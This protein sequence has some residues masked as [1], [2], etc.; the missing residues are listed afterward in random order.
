VPTYV[1]LL[2]G[3]NVGGRRSLPMATLRT[4][5]EGAGATAVKT[6]IQSGNAVFVHATKSETKLVAQLAAAIQK[7]AGFAVPVMLRSAAEIAAVIENNPF[8]DAGEDD[9]HVGFL[10][11]TPA[12]TTFDAAVYAPEEYALV[13]RELYMMLPAGVG[14]SKLAGALV[15]QKAFAPATTRNWRTVQKLVELSA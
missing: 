10:P 1:A 2:R 15:R 7:A 4:T 3:V 13:G 11:A 12:A 9:L 8:P 5:L 6:Y 14:K